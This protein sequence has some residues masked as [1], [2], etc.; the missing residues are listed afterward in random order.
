MIASAIKSG[1]HSS[2]YRKRAELFVNLYPPEKLQLIEA[3]KVYTI[4]CATTVQGIVR[5]KNF[6]KTFQHYVTRFNASLATPLRKGSDTLLQLTFQRLS[7]MS[8]VY[9]Q[10]YA[11]I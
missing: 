4:D 9:S 6:S 10:F 5:N 3:T 2:I 7:P 11:Q 1:I 8:E